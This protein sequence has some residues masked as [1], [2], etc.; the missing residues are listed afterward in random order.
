M[1]NHVFHTAILSSIPFFLFAQSAVD[2]EHLPTPTTP[3]AA[4]TSRSLA[5]TSR[6][7]S[8]AIIPEIDLANADAPS[9]A[10]QF[11]IK[12]KL[13]N[14]YNI[15]PNKGQW[16]SPAL[17]RLEAEGMRQQ[18]FANEVEFG[19]TEE[20]VGLLWSWQFEGALPTASLAPKNP[21]GGSKYVLE[22]DKTVFVAQYKEIW[23]ENIYKNID[24]GFDGIDNKGFNYRFTVR[25]SADI[26]D[27]RIAVNGVTSW[28]IDPLH[29]LNI[30][31]GDNEINTPSPK[32][33]QFIEGKK[34]FFEVKYVFTKDGFLGLEVDNSFNP[35]SVLYI[36]G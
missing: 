18:F 1:T 33:Y 28:T 6:S 19:I 16:H 25:P 31:I 23:Y 13:E 21:K 26:S 2:T 10:E 17:Y 29:S 36:I 3:S 35:D 27:I 8:A 30:T 9:D 14:K 4:A 5:A 20:N 11:F 15:R 12:P 7:L 24:I 22:R 32:A 34:K